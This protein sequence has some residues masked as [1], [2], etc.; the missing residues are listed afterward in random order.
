M[1]PEKLF[2][3]L[4]R[5]EDENEVDT[6]L[7]SEGYLVD[8]ESIWMP[9]G[10]YENNFSTVGNQQA[11]STGALVDKIINDLDAVLMA[12][13]FVRRT[14]PEGPDAPR[15]MAAA[16]EQFFGVRAGRLDSL[17]ARER[18]R[19]AERFQLRLVAVGSKEDPCYL[20]IDKGEGQTPAMF[21]DTFLSL[22]K[23]NKLRIPFVQGKFNAG[24]TGVLQSCGKRQNYQLIVSRRHPKAPV[25]SDDNTAGLWGFT[26][27]R[28]LP[29]SKG[30]KNSMYVYLAPGGKVFSFDT[31]AINVLPG[32]EAPNKPPKPYA[33]PLEYGTCI[34]LYNYRW[35]AK[36]TATTEA[37]YELERHLHA[38]CLP[39]R[40]TETR[41]Y[42]ANYYS[43][44]VSGIWAT[45]AS[46][47]S[48]ETR[49]EEGFPA[50]AELNISG[51][52]SLP[53]RIVV[54]GEGVMSRHVPHG[55]F[56]TV[57]GQVHGRLS[58]DFI[59]SRLVSITT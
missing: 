2:Y 11:N 47:D 19:L 45:V 28:R 31:Y 48:N 57:S 52:G 4:L 50:T 36:S 37:R 15:T 34:K 30:R 21:A 53:Y 9:L 41:D 55:V 32:E 6:I 59:K 16:V 23:S 22:N 46:E 24:G 42:R 33:K 38:P 14:S 40:V 7:S 17:S 8:D 49:V 29:P 27:V 18:T 44:T 54:Y 3:R 51:V 35:R 20:L 39:F 58:P 5:A 26:I 13:C 1:N 25:S 10:G 43:T 56:F 12:E